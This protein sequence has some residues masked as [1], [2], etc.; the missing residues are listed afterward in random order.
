MIK[1]RDKDTM[2]LKIWFE[3]REIRFTHEQ[4]K[5]LLQNLSMLRSGQYPKQP[6]GY[7]LCDS[8]NPNKG[9]AAF[10]KSCEVAGEI[11]TRLQNCAID[12]LITEAYFCN[13]LPIIRI[14]YYCDQ[15]EEEIWNRIDRCIR[16]C[17]GMK[18]KKQ[19][20]RNWCNHKPAT[21]E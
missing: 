19:N 8:F 4:V 10:T 16:Y 1:Y 11:D 17:S 15:T 12:G 9:N 21:S 18:R 14:M 3:M 6:V 5:F 20:Y 13:E 7:N 2:E